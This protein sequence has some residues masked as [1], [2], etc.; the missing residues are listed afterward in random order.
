MGAGQGRGRV[1]KKVIQNFVTPSLQKLA[2]EFKRKNMAQDDLEIFGQPHASVFLYV[3]PGGELRRRV[4][5]L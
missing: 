1:G 5:P 3:D 4:P 2:N